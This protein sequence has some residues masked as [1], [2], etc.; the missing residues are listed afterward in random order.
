MD[1]GSATVASAV[2]ISSAAEPT[3]DL[4]GEDPALVCL[5]LARPVDKS[6]RTRR[7]RRRA[8][9]ASAPFRF[10]RDPRGTLTIGFRPPLR[11]VPNHCELVARSEISC[12]CR[13][14]AASFCALGPDA[15]D[16]YA[17]T[18]IVPGSCRPVDSYVRDSLD[19]P[20]AL[21]EWRSAGKSSHVRSSLAPIVRHVRDAAAQSASASA[22]LSRGREGVTS[23]GTERAERRFPGRAPQALSRLP[24]RPRFSR[25]ATQS[26]TRHGNSSDRSDQQD[27]GDQT[28]L[29][30][31]RPFAPTRGCRASPGASDRCLRLV[32]P[33]SSTWVAARM[34]ASTEVVAHACRL[35]SPGSLLDAFGERASCLRSSQLTERTMNV[36]GCLRVCRRRR[37]VR[38]ASAAPLG[39]ART[40][41][42]GLTAHGP[43]D[44]HKST[45]TT[46]LRR[47]IARDRRSHRAR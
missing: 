16:Q 33:G 21:D 42:R 47:P 24:L 14:A 9:R 37:A 15:L 7:P 41:P 18:I 11:V 2:S 31:R 29:T 3:L 4:I 35:P 44:H 46:R 8:Y 39:N 32:R 25:L 13:A 45:V 28:Q 1:C 19:C 6:Y 10:P 27:E 5:A 20:M 40:T 22:G 34:A 43:G 36:C 30:L 17:M 12:R 23:A 38:Q 26:G